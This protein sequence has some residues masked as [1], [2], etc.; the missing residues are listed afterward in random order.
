[1]KTELWCLYLDVSEAK[2]HKAMKEKQ[3]NTHKYLHK[4]GTLIFLPTLY[5]YRRHRSRRYTAANFREVENKREQMFSMREVWANNAVS[6]SEV[7]ISE[8]GDVP[9]TS[10][11][12]SSHQQISDVYYL[13]DDT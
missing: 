2:N 7:C 4:I 10:S 8:G 9:M 13:L 3:K 1:M 12:S 6:V 5:F 11:T